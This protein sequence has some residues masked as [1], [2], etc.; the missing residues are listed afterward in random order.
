MRRIVTGLLAAALLAASV[1][2]S[3]QATV[4]ERFQFE[5]EWSFTE[6]CGFPVEVTGSGSGLFIVREG[7]NK[8]DGVFP[9]LNRFEYSETDSCEGRF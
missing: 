6:D 5:D 2:A 4:R 9:F 7:K 1:A 8:D 3:A